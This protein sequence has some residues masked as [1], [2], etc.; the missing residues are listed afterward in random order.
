MARTLHCSGEGRRGHALECANAS[1]IDKPG[2]RV[3]NRPEPGGRHP[4]I[5]AHARGPPTTGT[6]FRMHGFHS[7]SRPSFLTCHCH[8]GR[9]KKGP[10]QMLLSLE[11][12]LHAVACHLGTRAEL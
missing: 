2:A 10:R 4:T 12:A 9:T 3:P 11:M 1:P 6:C 7:V 8:W 5:A